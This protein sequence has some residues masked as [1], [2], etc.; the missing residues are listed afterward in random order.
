MVAAE[1]RPLARGAA[2][3]SLITALSRLTGFLRVVAVAAALGTTYVAN[4]YQSANS[5]PN[6][7]F[8]LVAAGVLTA[9]FV[10]AFVSY[11]TRQ[12]DEGWRAADALTTVAVVGLGA[13]ALLV[14]L[15][16]P[17]I[18]RL[19]LIGVQDVGEK[20]R[21]VAFGSDLLRLFSPQ[22]VLYG[23]GTIMTAALHAHRHFTMPA[24]APVFNNIVMIGVYGAYSV[25]RGG[26]APS[27]A[28]VGAGDTFLLGVGT[29]L[30]VL[31]MTLCLLP[32]LGRIGW[33]PRFRFEPSHPAVREGVRLGGWAL[34]YAG[35]YQAGLIVVLILANR[36]EGGVAAYQWAYTFFFLPHAL[37][38]VPIFNV[39]FTAMSEHVVR[40]EAQAVAKRLRD[41]LG[42]LSFILLPAA[43]ALA[44]VAGPLAR[45]TLEYGVMTPS[46]AALVGRVLAAFAPGLPFFSAFLVVTRAF[47]SHGDSKTPALVNAAAI[48]VASLLGP[49]LFFA[50][51]E[52]WAVPGLAAA[53]SFAFAVGAVLLARALPASYRF[54]DRDLASSI[55]KALLASV[56][57]GAAMLAVGASLPQSSRSAILLSLAAALAAGGATYLLLV[58]W[59]RVPELKRL[60]ASIRALRP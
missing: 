35:G 14:A 9:V 5:A 43:A 55:L 32:S 16:A 24:L 12:E 17:W 42:M 6:L 34:G 51:P 36:V 10:P 28:G 1:A 57:A 18:M 2:V 11:L 60:T 20:E 58:A 31:A 37:A 56:A 48:L 47:Y 7:V 33:R 46:G 38:G 29:T 25:R 23:A 45:A 15:L 40:G 53:H 44:V 49:L 54:W 22:I 8:E 52:R 39:L 19:L 3:I 4:T 59:M 27:L 13:L 26:S 41:G 50:L 21:A 30:G